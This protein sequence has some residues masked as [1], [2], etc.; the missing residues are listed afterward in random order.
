MHRTFRPHRLVVTL[1]VTRAPGLTD[2]GGLRIAT[3]HHSTGPTRPAHA[4]SG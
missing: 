1:A 3:E 2:G 4:R